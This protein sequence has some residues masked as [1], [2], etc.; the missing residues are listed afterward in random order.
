MRYIK[1]GICGFEMGTLKE[2][3][4]KVLLTSEA[5]DFLNTVAEDVHERFTMICRKIEQYGYLVSPYGEKIEGEN[6][7]FAMRIL[8]GNNVRFFYFYMDDSIY[9]WVLNGYEKRSRK[10]PKN[11]IRKALRIKRQLESADE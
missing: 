2:I 3:K 11:E 8:S 5:R 9:V 4:K 7:L 6:G 10:V 1:C